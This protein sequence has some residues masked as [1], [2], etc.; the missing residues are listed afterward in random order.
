MGELLTIALA[1]EITFEHRNVLHTQEME[2]NKLF[3]IYAL[4]SPTSSSMNGLSPP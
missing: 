3:F 1:V 2:S 4:A